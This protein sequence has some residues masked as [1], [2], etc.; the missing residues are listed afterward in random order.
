MNER[1]ESEVMLKLD[2]LVARLRLNRPG[3][4]NALTASMW[5][6]V[7]ERV[8]EAIDH[9]A[10]VLV[11]DGLGDHFSAGA[12]IAELRAQVAE[13][14][15]LLDNAQR[16]QKLQQTL[17]TLPIPTL[18]LIRGHCVGGGVG[19]ALCCDLRVATADAQFALTPIKLGLHYSL[20]DTR[21]L[22]SV[23]G[24]ARAREILMTARSV[25]AR[26]AESWHLVHRVCTDADAL[27][28]AA[29]EIIDRWLSASPEALAAT[30][31]V[32]S[33]LAEN[34][35]ADNVT[36]LENLFLAAFEG[37]DFAEG[38]QAFLE[39]RSPQFT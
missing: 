18:A 4:R 38:A 21:R 19:L 26:E 33:H 32:L 7:G 34:Q 29:A 12:D 39:K 31:R 24:L 27:E 13:P 2:G 15:K 1:S 20:A 10:R 37:A 14:Q 6:A 17:E 11:L 28:Q 36:E 23:V 16:V 30:K 22:A 25:D 35:N 8:A 5:S 3:K 9:G